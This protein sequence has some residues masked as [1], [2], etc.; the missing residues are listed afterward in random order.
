MAI[1]FQAI[2]PITTTTTSN[3]LS[4]S[5]SD[6]RKEMKRDKGEERYLKEREAREVKRQQR[7]KK[8]EE[9]KEKTEKRNRNAVVMNEK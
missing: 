3:I 2:S 1:P 7:E 4:M 8:R 9:K 5:Q 6:N